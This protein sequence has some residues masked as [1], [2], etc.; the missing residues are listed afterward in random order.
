MET[1]R[2]CCL[3]RS[4]RSRTPNSGTNGPML[5]CWPFPEQTISHFHYRRA[6]VEQLADVTRGQCAAGDRP[7]RRVGSAAPPPP[8]SEPC[9]YPQ[10]RRTATS[11]GLLRFATC[12]HARSQAPLTA[13]PIPASRSGCRGEWTTGRRRSSTSSSEPSASG[14]N[15]LRHRGPSTPSRRSVSLSECTITPARPL[16]SLPRSVG[17]KG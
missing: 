15:T 4:P 16:K 12:A 13:G 1:R 11:T 6:L 5:G 10:L 2:L 8:R 17:A 14:P 9:R 7:N 3:F